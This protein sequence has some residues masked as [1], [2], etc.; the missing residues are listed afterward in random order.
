M[1]AKI[2]FVVFFLVTQLNLFVLLLF[3]LKKKWNTSVAPHI[4]IPEYVTGILGKRVNIKCVVSARPRPKI[5]FWRDHDGRV[6]VIL[7]NNYQMKIDNYTEVNKIIFHFFSFISFSF[8]HDICK[9][10]HRNK[11]VIFHIIPYNLSIFFQFIL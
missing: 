9:Q 2:F 11:M 3:I 7:G 10:M 5:F 4:E 6:P 1:I 8:S